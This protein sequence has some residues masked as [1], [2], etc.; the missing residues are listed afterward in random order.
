MKKENMTKFYK[1]LAYIVVFILIN[2]AA[3]TLFFR[4]DLTKDGLYSISDVS[5]KVVSTLKEP[6]TVHVFFSQNLP[7]P[8]N[9]IERYLRDLLTEYGIYANRYF[10]YQFHDVSVKDNPADQKSDSTQI[11]A[12]NYGIYPVQIQNIE[13]DEVK[14]QKA[15]MGLAMIHGDMIEKLPTITSTE[16]LEYKITTS[17]QKMN[18]KISSLL[19]LENKIQVTLYLSSS[20]EIVAPYINVSGL[21]EYPVKLEKIVEELNEKNY[22]K[23]QFSKYDPSKNAEAMETQKK[24]NLF[25]LQW[26]SQKDRFG[27]EIPAG[28]GVAGLVMQYNKKTIEIPVI[29]AINVPL[30][31][32]QYKKVELDQI[33]KT[34]DEGIESLIDIN[35]NIGYL[36]DH[37]TLNLSRGYGLPG[38]QQEEPVSRFYGLLSQNYSV[39]EINLKEDSIPANI[40]CMIIARPKEEFSDYA[41]FQIDQFLMKGKTLAIFLDAFNEIM[42]AR[43][44]QQYF[45]R[46]QGPFYLPLKTGLEKLL[47]HYGIQIKNSYI[48]DEYCYKQRVDQRYGGGEQPIYFAPI[49]QNQNINHQLNFMKNIERLIM[50]KISPLELEQKQ[51]KESGIQASEMFSSSGKSWEMSGK[52]NLNPYFI[53][54]P[55]ST[56]KMKSHPLA[57]LLEGEFTSYFKGKAIPDKPVKEETEDNSENKEPSKD[58][59]PKKDKT[60]S[61]PDIDLNKLKREK[62]L[63]EKGQPGKILILASTEILKNNILD[64]EG[65]SPNAIFLMNSVDYLN[66]RED[67]ALMRSKRQAINLLEETRSGTKTFTKTFNILG[68]PILIIIMGLIIW[69]RRKSRKRK[70]QLM[71]KK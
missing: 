21:S 22:G 50:V 16:G 63:I 32:T 58:E 2:M 51:V 12:N 26:E 38:Q 62:S 10:N 56:E 39:K 29:R 71:F 6:L 54:P 13:K 66:N 65:V 35:E 14:F 48:M 43:Q 42:P 5:K 59:K 69:I 41:L 47:G 9:N 30:F 55:Q 44:N 28:T 11:L 20:L 7:A 37:G 45:N 49:I 8:Y 19:R 34:I 46:N 24:Y 1:F 52:I 15:Y 57:Y 23:L 60:E 31:G 40:N 53:S 70:I 4:M 17:I 18:N 64:E 3:T 36:S 68:L 27:K 61:K 33:K 25:R 67:I